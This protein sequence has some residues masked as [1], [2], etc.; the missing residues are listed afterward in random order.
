[1]GFVVNETLAKRLWPGDEAIGK[2][3]TVHRASQARADLGQPVT[4]NVIGVVADVH[5]FGQDVDPQPE[6]YVPNTLEVWPWVT[7]VIRTREG[8]RAIPALRRAVLDV[9]PRLPVGGTGAAGQGFRT[10]ASTISDGLEQ[11]RTAVTL[12]GAFAG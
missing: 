10:V 11:R 9:D 1:S 8:A 4:G 5:Q 7:L 6:V 2:R 3:M 12:L